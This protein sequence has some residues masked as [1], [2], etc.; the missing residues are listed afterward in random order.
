MSNKKGADTTDAEVVVETKNEISKSMPDLDKMDIGFNLVCK[1]LK[2]EKGEIR[3]FW[4]NGLVTVTI[5]GEKKPAVYLADNKGNSWV[6][7]TFTLVDS[8]GKLDVSVSPVPVELT[9]L[10]MENT[11]NDN[12]EKI[13]VARYDIRKLIVKK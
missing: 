6:S 3:R 10:E 11:K 2:M 1:Y 4:Y 12:G 7:A 9:F 5:D 8:L 13:Q